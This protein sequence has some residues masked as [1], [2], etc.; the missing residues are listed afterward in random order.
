MCLYNSKGQQAFLTKKYTFLHIS[1][2]HPICRNLLYVYI[3]LIFLNTPCLES[4]LR[5]EDHF[6]CGGMAPLAAPIKCFLG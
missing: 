2:K 3:F 1:S 6:L 5:W 4:F